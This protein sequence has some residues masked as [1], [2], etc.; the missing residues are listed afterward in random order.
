MEVGVVVTVGYKIIDKIQ[1]TWP[2]WF[3][4]GAERQLSLAFL[5]SRGHTVIH[6]KVDSFKQQ[7]R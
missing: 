3:G 2:F 5:Q 7:W 6:L 4:P 1:G